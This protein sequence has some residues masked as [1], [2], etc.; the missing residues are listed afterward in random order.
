MKK[1]VVHHDPEH[2]VSERFK[3]VAADIAGIDYEPDLSRQGFLSK[4]LDNFT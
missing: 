1:P 3:G 2:H 4:L